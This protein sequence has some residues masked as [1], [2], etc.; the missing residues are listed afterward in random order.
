MVMT[1]KQFSL[2]FGIGFAKRCS[3]ATTD[4]FFNDIGFKSAETLKLIL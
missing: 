2:D 4:R 1:W 3:T